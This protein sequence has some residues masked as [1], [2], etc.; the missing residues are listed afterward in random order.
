MEELSK[1]CSGCGACFLICNKN[2]IKFSMNEQGFY[3]PIVDK[4]RCV[5]CG[6]CKKVCIDVVGVESKKL[7]AN[8]NY[9]AAAKVKNIHNKSSSGGI[10]YILAKRA[11]E[12]GYAVCGVQYNENTERAEH[13]IITNNNKEEL[14]KLQ[15]SKYLQSYTIEAFGNIINYEKAIIFGTPCQIAGLNKVLKLLGKRENFVL[16][17]IFC[18]GVPSNLLWEN[19]LNYLKKKNRIKDNEKAYF[20]NKKKYVLKIGNKYE[21]TFQ[22]DAFYYFFIRNL[23]SNRACYSCPYRRSGFSDIRLGDFTNSKFVKL[24]YSP[25][26]VIINTDI[27]KKLISNIKGDIDIF[28]EDFNKVDLVQDFGDKKIPYKYNHYIKKFNEGKFPSEIIRKE[29]VFMYVKGTIKNF[30]KIFSHANKET[31]E[32]DIKDMYL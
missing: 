21:K 23:V 9:I 5:L 8:E 4:E 29:M 25:S 13:L 24:K 19:H 18:H 2:A 12:N 31:E 16:I 26:N 15:G 3:S 22:Y 32:D 10:A 17:D 11:L 20:R 1:N 27:G 7:N 30:I 28:R 6:R 14:Y